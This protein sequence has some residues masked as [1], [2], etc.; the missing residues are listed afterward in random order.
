MLGF[1]P[2]T[3]LTRTSSLGHCKYLGTDISFSTLKCLGSLN[4]DVVG[5]GYHHGRRLNVTLTHDCGQS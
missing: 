4:T 2:Q 1:L 3:I 5:L